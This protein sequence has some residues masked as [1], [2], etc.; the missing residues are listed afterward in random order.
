MN[1]ER[2]SDD[3]LQ[4]WKEIA[5]FLDVSPRRAQQWEKE[6]GMPVTRLDV[7][8]KKRVLTTRAQLRA[9]RKSLEISPHAVPGG[10]AGATRPLASR[11]RGW[12]VGVACAALIVISA[13]AWMVS[14]RR[15]TEPVGAEIVKGEVRALD[16]RGRV[17][18]R[19]LV[20]DAVTSYPRRAEGFLG[21]AGGGAW[22]SNTSI[23]VDFDGD[24][25]PDV[26]AVIHTGQPH[27]DRIVL[28]S[29]RGRERW[30]YHPGRAL[31]WEDRSFDARYVINW[32]LGPVVIGHERYVVVSASN[33]FFPCQISLLDAR[34]GRL[35]SEYWHPGA[36]STAAAADID[37]D[38]RLE[39]LAGGVNNPGPGAG[40]PALV[41]LDLP[42]SPAAGPADQVFGPSTGRHSRYLLFPSIDVFDVTRYP[43]GVE[44]VDW[45]DSGRVRLSVSLGV[46]HPAAGEVFYTLDSSLKVL[47]VRPCD[48]FR[49]AHVADER[50][51]I[52]SHPLSAA[53]MESW[54]HVRAYVTIPNANRP[55][56]EVPGRTLP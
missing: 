8:K 15:A 28:L 6:L 47:E 5:A 23:V 21:L 43:A 52:L 29:K 48:Q 1:V 38:G 25:V 44:R 51:G 33:E 42:F 39:L 37:R 45:D 16:E 11:L 26:L 32:V 30:S 41:V 53:D 12:R 9:W 3:P 49:M 27:N 40:R 55:G 20:P 46:N 50:T 10:A 4:S 17:V 34:S 7:G 22:R 2:D 14:S 19:H 36:L 24:A 18:W 13:G 31:Q 56:G 54:K 35:V